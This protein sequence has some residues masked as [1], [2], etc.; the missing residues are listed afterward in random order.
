MQR[1]IVFAAIAA[2]LVCANAATAQ[3]AAPVPRVAIVDRA[4][5]VADMSEDGDPRFAALLIGLREHGYVEGETIAI[6]RWSGEGQTVDGISAIVRNVVGSRPDVIVAAGRRLI[7]PFMAAT[8]TI[9]IVGHGTFPADIKI[10]RPGGNLTGVSSNVGG[11]LH[12]KRLQILQDA[13]PTASRIAYLGPRQ[14][15]EDDA[16]GGQLRAAAEQLDLNLVPVF[17]DVP[18]TEA[19]IRRAVSAAAE[20]DIDAVYTASTLIIP[21]YATLGDA[22]MAAKLPAMAS[23]TS[24]VMDGILMSYTTDATYRWQRVADYVARVLKGADPGELPIEQP[25]KIEFVINLNTADA[26]GITLPPKIMIMATEFI[27]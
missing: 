10:A 3:P 8:E 24:A 22:M 27:E 17:V 5:S 15:W 25:M 19:A 9:P 26:L 2:S 12:A 1:R 7:L 13:V 20:Q 6:E 16:L 11:L 23:R 18:V 4:A 14:W 21:H